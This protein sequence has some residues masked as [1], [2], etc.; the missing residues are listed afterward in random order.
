MATTID[1]LLVGLGFEYD[2]EELKLFSKDIVEVKDQLLGMVKVVVAGA[3]SL[4]GLAIVSAAATDAQGKLAKEI[5]ETV[6]TIDAL[7]F[8]NKIAGG[9]I[10]G[11]SNSLRNLSLRASEAARGIGSGVEIFGRLGISATNAEGRLKPVSELMLEVSDGLQGL[12]KAR[13]IEF[14]DKLGIRDSILL[15]QEGSSSIKNLVLSAEELGVATDEDAAIAANLTDSMSELWKIVKSG[16]RILTRELAPIIIGVTQTFKNWWIS[17]RELIEQ[18]LPKWVE[19]LTLALKILSLAFAAF[20]GAK[21]LIGLITLFNKATVAAMLMN[22]SVLAL[23]LLI[24]AAVGA[25]AL[26]AE[27]AYTFFNGGD[28]FIG[29]MLIKFPKWE[30]QIL[31][32]ASVFGTLAELTNMIFDGWKEIISLF[33]SGTILEDIKNFAKNLPGFIGDVTGISGANT[34]DNMSTIFS[35]PRADLANSVQ[36]ISKRTGINIQ[37]LEIPITPSPSQNAADIAKETF[38][39]FQQAAQDLETTV[40]Q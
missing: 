5:G 3:A 13:Q 19:K 27:D 33:D 12:D 7:Q 28:S 10:D 30:G 15:L 21:I 40:D 31:K 37:K 1:E 23:P 34:K 25:I 11:M 22:A 24:G 16:A 38:N 36:N 26:L 29:D 4:T 9:S 2:S 39:I 14:A 35:T 32:I 8:A 20:A 6:S 17:N 18:D